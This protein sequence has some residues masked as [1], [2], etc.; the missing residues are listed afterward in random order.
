MDD[1]MTYG[2]APFF[3]F[4]SPQATLEHRPAVLRLLTL[5]PCLDKGEVYEV[6]TPSIAPKAIQSIAAMS[7]NSISVNA[8][9]HVAAYFQVKK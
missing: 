2:R 5:D 7:E 1:W 3:L 8:S 6:S 4:R 9:E